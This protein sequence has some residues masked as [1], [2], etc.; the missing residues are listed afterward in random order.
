MTLPRIFVSIACY[1]DAECPHTLASLFSQA[2]HPERVFAGVLWQLIPEE[3]DDCTEIPASVPLAQV[4]EQRVHAN[5][6]KGA[7]WARHRILAELWKGEEFVLQIDSHTRFSPGWDERFIDMLRACPSPRAVLSSYP[8]PYTPPDLLGD[9]RIPIQVAKQF[10]D[11]GVL[12]LH[13]RVLPYEMRPPV[14]LPSAFVGAGC[15]FTP[16]EA[17][18]EVPYDPRLYFHGEEI[19]MA[20]RLWTHGWDL[21]TPNDILLYHDYRNAT[22]PRHWSDNRDWPTMSTR[23]A[24]R[25]RCLLARE[26]ASDPVAV[27]EIERY[28]LGTARTLEEYEAYADLDFRRRLIG[29][30][31]Q[32]GRFPLAPDVAAQARARVFTDIFENNG[33]GRAETRSGPGSTLTATTA[34]RQALCEV[35]SELGVRSVLDV[36][37]GDL[38]WIEHCLDGVDLYL[39]ID[40]APA[41]IAYNIELYG[42]R[43]GMFFNVADVV[44]D[45]LPR[46]DAVLCRHVFTHLPNRDV[47]AALE[48][49]RRSGA[50]YLI[51]TCH[52]G[53][54]NT[55]IEPGKWRALDLEAPPFQLPV[56]IRTIADGKGVELHVWD[57][58]A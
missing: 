52:K 14:P 9:P 1:R 17:L 45:A 44:N 47:A 8:V 19:T 20:A 26:T 25:L 53:V 5:E 58:R 39:G 51:A 11:Q 34:M 22:R 27:E 56:P 43:K 54:S 7:C 48:N 13:S 2:L 42:R 6:S 35:F 24:M 46:V 4:R 12:I 3:D 31:A 21:F 37:C 18:A 10:N 29:L 55:D 38:N 28:G 32:D 33:W 16:G 57:M 41:I 50:S 15:L 23:A 49:I 40:V 30:R 36:G